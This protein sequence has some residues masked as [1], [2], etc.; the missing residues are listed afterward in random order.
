MCLP[1][2]FLLFL[3]IY[4]YMFWR[5]AGQ[6][7][8]VSS[9]TFLSCIDLL[10]HFYFLKSWQKDVLLQCFF[11]TKST[12]ND[13]VLDFPFMNLP[14]RPF[15]NKNLSL[16]LLPWIEVVCCFHFEKIHRK[17]HH[18]GLKQVKKKIWFELYNFLNHD[19]RSVFFEKT[20]ENDVVLAFPLW[21]HSSTISQTKPVF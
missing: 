1:S 19:F 14:L 7:N 2:P 11:E 4:I 5:Q 15:P 9:S 20:T 16:G 10:I 6:N 18:F 3:Y 21:T 13:I 12:I 8:V 17:Q